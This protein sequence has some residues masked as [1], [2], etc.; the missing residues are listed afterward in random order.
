MNLISLRNRAILEVL[1]C[2]GSRVSEIL[3]VNRDEIDLEMGEFSDG[4]GRKPRPV[5][6]L[7]R[8]RGTANVP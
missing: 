3:N 6:L 5:F 7:R 8:Y 1:Y 2:T 4:K